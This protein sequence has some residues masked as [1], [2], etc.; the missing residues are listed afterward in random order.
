[1]GI[2]HIRSVALALLAAAALPAPALG[3]T[4]RFRVRYAAEAKL[5]VT[6]LA[7]RADW[8]VT[9]HES[10]VL[11]VR[12]DGRYATSIVVFKFKAR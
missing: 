8:G 6:A 12:L 5:A 7:P 10:A 9:G 4:A 2:V 1:M 11:S 3:A